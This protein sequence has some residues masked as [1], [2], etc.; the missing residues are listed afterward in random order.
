MTLNKFT[1][2]DAQS[3][4]DV[5]VAIARL[6]QARI[7]LWRL[8]IETILRR[9]ETEGDLEATLNSKSSNVPELRRMRW[10][11]ATAGARVPWRA[12]CLVQVIAGAEW[13]RSRGTRP[14]TRFGV[15]LDDSG[16]LAAHAWLTVG[17]QVVTGGSV[18]GD[19]VEL[20]AGESKEAS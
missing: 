3:F 19:F 9:L 7:L 18:E 15:K 5:F 17:E 1:T 12:D 4:I 10:A 6:L 14:R 11:L 16:A 8:P 13:L 20:N 2:L